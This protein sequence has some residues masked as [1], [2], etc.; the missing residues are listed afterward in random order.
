MHM[1]LNIVALSPNAWNGQWVNRQQLLS[2]IG[3]E[4]S[5]IYSHG[6]W[7]IWERES[8]EFQQAPL[9]G[10]FNRQDNVFV[11]VPLR[12]TPRWTR[13]PAWDDAVM[14]QAAR[15][16]RRH[17]ARSGG[18]RPL[19][20]YLCHPMFLP[21][22]RHLRPD[23]IVYH[24]YD[25]FEQQPGWT[26]EFERAERELL[27]HAD[28]VFSP[29]QM[30]C[31]KLMDKAPCQA[32]ELLNA[33]DVQAIFAAAQAQVDI[34][35]D[36]ARIASPRLGYL[37]SIHPQLDFPLLDGLAQRRPEMNF[38]LIGP[39][40]NTPVLHADAGYLACK[41]R[42]NIHFLGARHRSEIPAYLLHMDANLMLYRLTADSWTHVAYPLKLHE[43][44]ACGKPV[45]S[46]PLAPIMEFAPVI[47][48]AQGFDDWERALVSALAEDNPQQ[49]A[50]RRELAAQHS[51]ERRAQTL[52][53]WLQQLP[54]LRA[55]RLARAAAQIDRK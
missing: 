24:C 39:E 27:R 16:W 33:A 37:G 7:S 32:R 12:L 2:R 45:V 38:V 15:R 35:A 13:L 34:P 42:P 3:T 29:T 6:N 48:F 46:V 26:A 10:S 14:A 11:D 22:V 41:S 51:W 53:G 52:D 17:L 50:Q 28:L 25:L 47:R 9:L 18:A 40:Q 54:Q 19:V 43:Y 44:L 20:A 49:C 8:A 30:L 36:L 21:Y 1:P 5:I 55:L 31:N 23:H 4:H